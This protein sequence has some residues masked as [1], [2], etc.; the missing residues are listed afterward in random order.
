MY[1]KC[2]LD[3]FGGSGSHGIPDSVSSRKIVYDHR[4]FTS[5]NIL[6]ATTLDILIMPTLT[7]GAAIRMSNPSAVS[8]NGIT[9]DSGS[10]L[11]RTS[12]FP[13]CIPPEYNSL[14]KVAYS[15]TAKENPFQSGSFRIVTVGYKITYTGKPTEASGS[16]MVTSCP[17]T[18]S[19]G[20]IVDIESGGSVIWPTFNSGSLGFTLSDITA[21]QV[22]PNLL[23][24]ATQETLLVRPDQGVKG[25]LKTNSSALTSKA[26][27][28]Q[29]V[30][31][32]Y[33]FDD[34][35][36]LKSAA[37]FGR[38]ALVDGFTGF[39]YGYDDR[40]NPTMATYNGLSAGASLLVEVITC[41]EYYPEPQSTYSKLAKAS[42][43][44][45]EQTIN[46][47]EKVLADSPAASTFNSP[48]LFTKFL[49]SVNVISKRTAPML[50]PYSF[51]ANAISDITGDLSNLNM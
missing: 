48:S 30:L 17:F 29:P 33:N 7:F 6:G 4:A 40:F 15:A 10:N 36:T 45:S 1:A 37:L 9:G 34:A 38:T 42:T 16:V 14:A 22:D 41:V 19:S 24:N 39:V 18:I 27:N 3:P 20:G 8:V 51:V 44:S 28:P 11:N 49:Q 31:P 25:V 23:N 47:V 46:L 50:G 32:Y 35:G 26:W 5:I 2:R 21:N 13:I 43:K 12:L